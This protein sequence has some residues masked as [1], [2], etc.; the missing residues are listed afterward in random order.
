MTSSGSPRKTAFRV[1]RWLIVAVVAVLLLPYLLTPLYRVIDPVSTLMLARWV[2]GKRVE[3]TIVPLERVAPVLPRS[4]DRVRGRPVLHPS[5]H[6][7]DRTSGR[8][9]RRRRCHRG[10]GRLDHHPADRQEPVPVAGPQLH[11]QGPGV[12][13]GAVD[14]SRAAEA[15]DHGDL[16]QY[17]R[18][19]PE[20]RI[21]HRGRAR[22][23]PS[24]SPAAQLSPG[25]AALLT[26]MLPNPK[27]RSAKAPRPGIRR[28]AGI[29]PGAGA[30]RSGG[31]DACLRPKGSSLGGGLPL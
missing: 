7:L 9:R 10:E 23:M 8:A 25:E 15:A 21:R 16:P 30:A 27:R 22:A 18:M 1:V 14:R 2:V 29:Y 26:A 24:T 3:R 4:R 19:G 31:F 28:V 12:P 13:A 5:R 20:R 6:R 11:P 17:R